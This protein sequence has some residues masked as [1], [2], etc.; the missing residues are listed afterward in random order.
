MFSK[1][2]IP[3]LPRQFIGKWNKRVY[4]VISELGRGANGTVY[5]ALFQGKKLAVKVGADS[6]D[7]LME[8][9]MLKNVHQAQSQKVGPLV[10]DLDDVVIDGKTLSFYAMEYVEGEPLDRYVER[11]GTEWVPVLMVQLL[12]R[13]GVLHGKGWAFGDLKPQN[14]IVDQKS[15]QVCL[16]D[17]GGVTKHGNAI[18]Q[19]TEEYDRA[20]WQAGDRRADSAYDLFSL[21]VMMIRLMIGKEAWKTMPSGARQIQL[22]C[23]I[24]RD[25]ESLYPFRVPLLKA[26]HGKYAEAAEMKQDM[27][28]SISE[29]NNQYASKKS[30][31]TGGR[32]VARLFVVLLLIL[33]G[34]MFFAWM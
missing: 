1:Q 23:D 17:F 27:L 19:F 24:I 33:A 32:W 22:L 16:I 4:S 5:L 7:L 11:V 30:G 28:H 3:A 34:S 26:F 21:A 13:L 12:S 6:I 8:V 9:N 14:V 31:G 25:N 10:T 20:H 18:R 29:R 15:K 2:A